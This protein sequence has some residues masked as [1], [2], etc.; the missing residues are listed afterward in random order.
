MSINNYHVK[1][2]VFMVIFTIILIL[3]VLNCQVKCNALLKRT[4]KGVFQA[5]HLRDLKLSF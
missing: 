5:K 3:M 2:L 4:S 1:P